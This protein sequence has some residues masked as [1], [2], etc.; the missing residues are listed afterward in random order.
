MTLLEHARS[1]SITPALSFGMSPVLPH[2]IS[3]AEAETEIAK[4]SS[5]ALTVFL[6]LLVGF[7]QI[8]RRILR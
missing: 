4:I 8:H 2:S 1:V 7:E 5:N 3:P 6:P